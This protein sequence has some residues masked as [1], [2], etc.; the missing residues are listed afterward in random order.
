MGG[1][2]AHRRLELPRRR[3]D[4]W[5]LALGAIALVAAIP[6]AWIWVLYASDFG[7]DLVTFSAVALSAAAAAIGMAM[8]RALDRR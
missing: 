3:A 1:A 6:L 4:R 2:S 7:R 8:L 5:L